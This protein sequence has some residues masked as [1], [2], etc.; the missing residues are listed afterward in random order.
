M[1]NQLQQVSTSSQQ[2]GAP[3]ALRHLNRLRSF[4]N[5]FGPQQGSQ[6]SQHTGSSQHS[7]SGSQ[8]TGSQ[9]E[10]LHLNRPRSFAN[11]RGRP[12]GS[13]GSKHSGSHTSTSSSQQAGSSQQVGWQ[14]M[15]SRPNRPASAG[16]AVIANIS[17]TMASTGNI[18]RLFMGGTPSKERPNGMCTQTSVPRY[19]GGI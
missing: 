19:P 1:N 13:Q 5:G 11:G 12:H 17:A 3:Q 14:Q 15:P 7:G 8:Q 9:Q 4:S 6:G 16:A 18:I 10:L 2:V